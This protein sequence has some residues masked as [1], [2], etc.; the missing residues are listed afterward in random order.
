[1]ADDSDSEGNTVEL[2]ESELLAHFQEVTGLEDEEECTAILERHA[3]VIEAAVQD[4]LNMAEG[5]EPVFDQPRPPSPPPPPPASELRFRQP[6]G[7]H[8]LPAVRPYISA[9]IAQRHL[10]TTWT[11]WLISWSMMPFRFVYS[12][13]HGL[14]HFITSL[15]FSQRPAIPRDPLI[16]VQNFIQQFE[17]SY[18][19]QHIPFL[20]L[21]YREAIDGVRRNISHLLVYLHSDNHRD[22]GEFC[23]TVLC[24]EQLIQL[25]T[26]FDCQCWGVSVNS[27]EGAA[28]SYA[29]RERSYPFLCLISPR[30]NRMSV[31]ARIEGLIT[32]E[33]LVSRLQQALSFS[34][35]ELVAARQEKRQ[36]E[37]AQLLR[38]QQ[39]KAYLDSLKADQEKEQKKQDEETLLQRQAE[40]E[41]EMKLAEIAKEQ[42]LAKEKDAL[43]Q[44]LPPEPPS[45]GSDVVRIMFKLPDGSRFERRF[46]KAD[47]LK[48][49]YDYVFSNQET[50]AQ[51]SLLINYPRRLLEYDEE[52]GPRLEQL[53]LDNSCILYVQDHSD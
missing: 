39:D 51:F 32:C 14:Y 1:M 50:S 2:N 41:E 6:Q 35:I 46:N 30:N 12:I 25:V 36:R 52:G 21:P 5:A 19:T 44:S 38:E 3:W 16:D 33:Q 20:P 40:E 53:G 26:R 29:L 18:G 15:I 43:L 11:E 45:S 48:V 42:E 49:V 23:R 9:P 37:Q 31:I 47:K 17:Q 7:Q 4:T 28:V 8:Q 13:S 10:P 34:D 24:N 27:G 22:T